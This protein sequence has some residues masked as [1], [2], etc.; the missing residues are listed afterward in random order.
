MKLVTGF[1]IAFLCVGHFTFWSRLRT[2]QVPRKYLEIYRWIILFMM[3]PAIPDEITSIIKMLDIK[4]K[5]LSWRISNEPTRI[6]VTF[7]WSK[8]R[9]IMEKSSY[10]PKASGSRI[11]SSRPNRKTA[12]NNPTGDQRAPTTNDSSKPFVN[13]T[14]RTN[15]VIGDKKQ[16]EIKKVS[17]QAAE[18]TTHPPNTTE[19]PAHSKKQKTPSQ[20]RRDKQ[21]KKIYRAIKQRDRQFQRMKQQHAKDTLGRASGTH[22][23]TSTQTIPEQLPLKQIKLKP[24]QTLTHHRHKTIY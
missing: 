22:T 24:L 18:S 20:K 9:A 14:K 10:R 19:Q 4:D 1:I 3:E 16:D 13:N 5:V 23:S 21:R 17:K 11:P 12:G 15:S 7:S 6:S 2:S 8:P